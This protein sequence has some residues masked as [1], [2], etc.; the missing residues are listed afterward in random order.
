ML[1]Q[2]VEL[3]EAL[4]CVSVSLVA[5]GRSPENWKGAESLPESGHREYR[6]VYSE[7]LKGPIDMREAAASYE[8]TK[9]TL[10]KKFRWTS[11][12]SLE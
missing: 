1:G 9:G 12:M 5:Q 10:N 6:E 8:S 11:R 4:A 7:R 2:V 3:F